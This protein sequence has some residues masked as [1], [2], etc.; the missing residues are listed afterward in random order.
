MGARERPGRPTVQML[1][2]C[3]H[4]QDGRLYYKTRPRSHFA[5]DRTHHTWNTRN[6]GREAG[7]IQVGRTG[8]LRCKITLSPHTLR[9][10][11]VVW[12]MHRGEWVDLI[13]HVNRDSL[14][15]RMEN[16][17]L[18]SPGQNAANA[19][20]HRDNSSGYKGVFWRKD[21]QKWFARIR[22]DGKNLHLGV[23]DDPEQAHEAYKE[24]ARKEMGAFSFDG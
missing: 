21:I 19:R 12:A 6:A 16:L 7:V 17:R 3:F 18:A 10:Y 20:K 2:E 5:D 14:D 15:D 24:A 22:V 13:D 8:N 9:R 4:Y 11:Q 1:H 23:F